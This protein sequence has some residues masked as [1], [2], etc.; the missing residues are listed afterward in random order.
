MSE[1]HFSFGAAGGEVALQQVAGPLD[2]RLVGDRRAVLAAAEL[3]VEPVLG[4]S[5]R[6]T[7]SRPTP[8]PRRRSS[9]QVLRAP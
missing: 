1:T 9:C 3:A 4:A 5:R 7:W 8:I 2:R 6:A